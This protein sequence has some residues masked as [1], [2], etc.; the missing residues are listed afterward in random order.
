MKVENVR[1]L[2]GIAAIGSLSVITVYCGQQFE[3]FGNI[4]LIV[5]G[6]LGLAQT[7]GVLLLF[8]RIANQDR[9]TVSLIGKYAF[10]QLTSGLCCYGFSLLL[11]KI[12]AIASTLTPIGAAIF[13]TANSIHL[14]IIGVFGVVIEEK[15]PRLVQ[16]IKDWNK[17]NREQNLN[18]LLKVSLLIVKPVLC[19]IIT[20]CVVKILSHSIYLGNFFSP[21]FSGVQDFGA[22]LLAGYLDKNETFSKNIHVNFVISQLVIG[23]GLFSVSAAAATTG[24]INLSHTLP[25]AALMTGTTLMLSVLATKAIVLLAQQLYHNEVKCEQYSMLVESARATPSSRY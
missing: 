3:L 10:T 11:V 2:T 14:I 9:G 5:S 8:E 1:L 25:C 24:V 15:G 23:I 22:T 17:K 19:T 4:N 21:C 12:G 16:N 13:V 6:L 18:N 7:G 20:A